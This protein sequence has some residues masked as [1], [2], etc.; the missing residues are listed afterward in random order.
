MATLD[1]VRE[2]LGF[3]VKQ[4]AQWLRLEADDATDASTSI[5]MEDAG[6]VFVPVGR[7]VE[8]L[9]VV[10]D[11]MRLVD[12]KD[13]GLR[14]RNLNELVFTSRAFDTARDHADATLRILHELRTRAYGKVVVVR[15]IATGEK[16]VLR[17]AQANLGFPEIGVI[18]RLAPVAQQLVSAGVGDTISTPKGAYEVLAVAHMER[19]GDILGREANFRR[20]D[21]IDVRLPAVSTLEDLEQAVAIRQDEL[22]R[23]VL[24]GSAVGALAE[25]ETPD[26]QRGDAERLSAHFYTRTTKLQEALMQRPSSGLLIVQGVAGSGKT[27]VALGRTK[28]LCDRGPAEGEDDPAYFRP[29][30]AVG[31]VLNEQL[32]TY[33]GKA[34][35]T[36][37]LFDMKIREYRDLREELLRNRNLDATGLERAPERTSDP[38]E[39]SMRWVRALDGVMADAIADSLEKAV[40]VPPQE[41]ESARKQVATRT[42][43]QTRAL[44]EK[45]A[46][47]GRDID[48]VV[49]WLRRRERP[50]GTLRL[51]GLAVRLDEPRA[52]FARE[53]E[54]DPSWNGPKQRDLRQNVRN[55]LRERIIR[56]VRLTDAYGAAL[57][58]PLL[59][60][61]LSTQLPRSDVERAIASARGSLE[62]GKLTDAAI[63]ALLAIAH[64][65][66]LGY[67][68]RQDR[69][70]I[71][72]LAQPGFFSQVFIDEY[73]DFTEVQ[74]HLMG[75]QA[76]PRRRAV[77]L[78]GDL[79]QQL[80]TVRS[81]DI[82]ACFPRA[83]DEERLPTVLLENKRQTGT[84]ARLSQKFRADFL[85]DVPGE[86]PSFATDGVLPRLISATSNEL[87]QAIEAE[88]IRLPKGCSV[89][90]ICATAE[91]AKRLEHELRDPLTSQF[92]ETRFS[93]HSD[94]TRR[95]FVHFTTALDAKGLEFDAAIVPLVGQLERGDAIAANAMYVAI[96]RPRQYL[97]IVAESAGPFDAWATEGLLEQVRDPSAS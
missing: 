52:R 55:A 90:V 79:R 40:A 49:G 6:A 47:L 89:A 62:G 34:C 43:E 80:R 19:F 14:G 93:T 17:V 85:G 11:L 12:E 45:W 5:E 63:D 61:D 88:V 2:A 75:S 68:G 9:A 1:S 23:A 8:E 3:S 27:S 96:S 20:M 92:R 35:T 38:T 25:I 64:S 84:L 26:V 54:A 22:R 66:S 95:F 71:S 7:A 70:P 57:R 10:G 86:A 50:T 13:R 56:A 33:L 15:D 97:T 69:D 73:Q 67:A 46:G 28:V 76:E 32:A 37:A 4:L 94:L 36:L 24:D 60:T 41:R 87:A 58:S 72:H 83:K 82:D 18:N 59:V 91:V 65:L 51:E 74:I 53:L 30:T 44:E 29:E 16:R 31:F 78:V 81:L 42:E 77:T 48:E 21:L 39:A